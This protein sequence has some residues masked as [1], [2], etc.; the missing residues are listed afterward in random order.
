M[1]AA[2]GVAAARF[3]A[4]ERELSDM[5]RV[6]AAL[7]RRI[8]DIPALQGARAPAA[9]ALR[10][11]Q[12]TWSYDELTAAI[13]RCATD[14]TAAGV[15]GGD[16]VLI[17]GENCAAFVAVLLGTARL[18]AWAVPVNARLSAREIDSIR[19][20]CAPRRVVY[21]AHVSPD[22][23]A[24]AARH[25]ATEAWDPAEMGR[26]LLG[27]RDDE[28]RPEA[29][30]EDSAMQVAALLYTS[31]T[32]GDPK[33]VMLTHRNLL[34]IARLSSALRMLVESDLVYGVLP[35][36]HV[37]G[38]ASVCLGTLFAGACVHLEPRYS[39][40][41]L[42]RALAQDGITV[43]QGVP[44]MYAKLLDFL[45]SSGAPL[46][47]P[48]LRLCY[49]GGSPLTPALK[50]GAERTFGAPLHNGYGLT[51]ASPTIAHTRLDAPRDDC[52]VGRILPGLEIRIAN[53]ADPR[54]GNA[55]EGEPGELWVRGPNVMRGYYRDPTLTARNI[56][57]EGWLNTG[58]IARRHPDGALFIVGRT[59]ELI[60]HSGFNV[61]PIEVESV[62]NAH[63]AVSQSAVI[64]RP[65]D[66]NEEVVA[67]V[68]L[69]PGAAATPGEIARFAAERLAPYKRPAEVVI[70]PALPTAATGK[71]LKHRLRAMATRPS[72]VMDEEHNRV[73]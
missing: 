10:E 25:G 53:L 17:I 29:V 8:S 61:Y 5:A 33:G 46:D 7:P 36:S 28:C 42:L 27:R 63:P 60:I 44:S 4:V 55:L 37:Y 52:S 72:V 35:I 67:F 2:T 41:A 49:A 73:A 39:P 19:A 16:R 24:H 26:G 58:D 50:A 14:L 32:T 69:S 51:E 47:A 20:H 13:E 66:G 54:H 11:G 48:A 38:L 70:L 12:R 21:L 18:D 30:S 62:L 9:P 31:G 45:R 64:G 56:D 15:R 40:Q 57:P 3:A 6:L 1:I 22:A 71:I 34:Y 65:V 59:K 43:L 23:A 68:E